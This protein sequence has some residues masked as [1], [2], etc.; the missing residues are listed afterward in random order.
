VTG[1]PFTA[2]GLPVRPDVTDD[3]VRAAWRR[4]AAATHPDRA[5]GGDP[6]RYAA[7]GA[8]YTV[9][10]TGY[11]RGEAYADLTGPG[12]RSLLACFLGIAALASRVSRGRPVVLALRLAA[13][14]G[15]AA[16]A[17]AIA[18]PQPGSAGLATGALTWFILTARHDLA[19]QETVHR[20]YR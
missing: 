2:L 6:D 8:A 13:A 19:A 5:D 7:A 17:F 12:Q 16:A 3:D 14:A 11:G 4:I 15:V 20:R 1:D 18:G 10:R 9:L